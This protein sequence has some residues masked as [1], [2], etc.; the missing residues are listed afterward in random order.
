[1]LNKVL[2]AAG[3]V[4]LAAGLVFAFRPVSVNGVNCGS[5]FQPATGITPMDC[6]NRVADRERVALILGGAGLV[7]GATSIGIAMLRDR[8]V[9]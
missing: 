1:M 2:G 8:R 6:D 9:R 7:V 4:L 5:V 3:L